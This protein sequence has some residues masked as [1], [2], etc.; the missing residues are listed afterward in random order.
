M[1]TMFQHFKRRLIERYNLE[2]TAEEYIELCAAKAETIEV[3]KREGRRI[4]KIRFKEQVVIAVKQSNKNKF[5][6][7]ALPYTRDIKNKTTT[8]KQ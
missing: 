2:I 3:L 5:L 1:A 4:V 7:T 8:S 6:I